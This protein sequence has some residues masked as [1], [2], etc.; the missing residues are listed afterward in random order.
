MD[1]EVIHRPGV[2]H[3]APDALSRLLTNGEDDSYLDEDVPVFTITQ[4]S[5]DGDVEAEGG[6]VTTKNW[7]TPHRRNEDA[8]PKP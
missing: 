3:R 8:P 4:S 2:K 5:I 1:F 7:Q 6:E